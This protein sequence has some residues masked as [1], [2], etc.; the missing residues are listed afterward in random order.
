[1]EI[2]LRMCRRV[3][4]R[5]ILLNQKPLVRKGVEKGLEVR[6]A[7]FNLT[8]CCS[9]KNIAEFENCC[10]FFSER[11]K[12]VNSIYLQKCKTLNSP[13]PQPPPQPPPNQNQP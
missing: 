2:Q 12:I 11:P 13:Q 6:L 8:L 3:I 7:D 9:A 5:G 10:H 1:M 4:I